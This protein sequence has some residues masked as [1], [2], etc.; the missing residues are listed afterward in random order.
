MHKL[1]IFWCFY[2]FFFLIFTFTFLS[3]PYIDSI[4]CM[5]CLTGEI[6]IYIYIYNAS[7]S[8]SAR[9]LMMLLLLL[10][11]HTGFL[12]RVG[13]R[14]PVRITSTADSVSVGRLSAGIVCRR[15]RWLNGKALVVS[16]AY[17]LLPRS[18]RQLLRSI[19]VV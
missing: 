1:L 14:F 16:S 8:S 4:L 6:K 11:L 3:L 12:L 15:C 18:V 19:L 13:F 7:S 2:Y 17:K 10:L 9:K 5:C